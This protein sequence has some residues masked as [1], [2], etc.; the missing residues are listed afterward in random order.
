MKKT[1]KLLLLFVILLSTVLLF[2][3]CGTI[4]E[5]TNNDNAIEEKVEKEPEKK[6]ETIEETPAATREFTDSTGR[7]VTIPANITKIAVSGQR[8]RT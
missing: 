6:E 8:G 2:S 3:G 1:K 5:Q 4:S 7:K